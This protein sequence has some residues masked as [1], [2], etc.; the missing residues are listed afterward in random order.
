MLFV[1]GDTAWLGLGATLPEARGRG[2]QS[3]LL[4]RRIALAGELGCSL[5]VTET[6]ESVVGR[7]STSH[8]NILRAGF[9]E[10]YLRP[11]YASPG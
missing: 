10:Q 9:R 5:C 8:R 11:N 6:G 1:H 2:S 7:P 3:A 4:A